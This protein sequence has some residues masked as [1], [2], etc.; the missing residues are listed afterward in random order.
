MA[1]AAQFEA[2][3]VTKVRGNKSSSE[4]PDS[5]ELTRK[6]LLH[7]EEPERLFACT[8][9]F[10]AALVTF[11]LALLLVAYVAGRA[12]WRRRKGCRLR[13]GIY[14][15]PDGCRHSRV[16]HDVRRWHRQYHR[17]R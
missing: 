15:N 17:W 10:S 9:T 7:K 8:R 5:L 14:H 2:E 12:S 1:E 11:L 4:K 13:S 16:D 3:E 6:K